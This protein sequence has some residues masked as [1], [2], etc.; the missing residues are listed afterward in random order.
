MTSI[1]ATSTQHAIFV[2]DIGKPLVYGE[3]P[4]PEPPKGYILIKVLSTMLLPHDTYGRDQGLFIGERLPYILGTNIAG[5]VEKLGDDVTSFKIGDHVF[6]QG[7]PVYPTPDSAGLQEYAILDSEAAAKIPEGVEIDD[8]VSFPVNATT[9]FEALFHP[10]NGFGFPL[11]FTDTSIFPRANKNIDPAT[12][13]VVIIGGGSNVGKLAIQFANIAR[14]GRIITVA[15]IRNKTSLLSLG[16][17]HIID[18]HDT[19]ESIA[20][21]IHDIVQRENITHV[22]DCVSWEFSLALSIVSKTDASKILTL[23]PAKSGVALAQEQ[24]FDKCQVQFVAGGN[25]F[26]RPLLKPF[27][28]YL[29][30]WVKEGKIVIPKY[31]VIEGFDLELIESALDDYRDGSPVLPAVVHP[32]ARK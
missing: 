7:N 25:E 24:G 29:P 12:Q 1:M 11:P 8:A 27:W 6:G 14:I 23:H 22:Y 18:R 19:P 28:K 20:K 9:S 13:T 21:Q 3:R 26:L 32:Q 10:E 15:S 16:A 2:K 17:T 31:R 4:I 30:L 5:V